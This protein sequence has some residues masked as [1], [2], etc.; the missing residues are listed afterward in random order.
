MAEQ[1]YE[2]PGDERD[3]RDEI[4]QLFE[5][6]ARAVTSGD[7]KAVAAMWEAPALVADDEAVRAVDS[8]TEV[9]AFFGDAKERYNARGVVETRAEVQRLELVT[10]RLVIAD[11]RW[12]YL[13]EHGDEIGGERSTY[14]LRRDDAGELRIR[15]VLMRG[16]EPPH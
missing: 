3:T 8:L 7:G 11:L 12:P 4:Q 13:D 9:E 2:R 14:W 5:H 1:T 10:D 6:L 15:A 16:V